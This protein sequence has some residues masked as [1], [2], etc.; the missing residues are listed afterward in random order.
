VNIG[1]LLPREYW[2]FYAEAIE[3]VMSDPQL[4]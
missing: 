3:R 4:S 1:R 2:G